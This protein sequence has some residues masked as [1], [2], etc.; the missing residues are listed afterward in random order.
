MIF[1]RIC[2]AIVIIF[3]RRGIGYFWYL[4]YGWLFPKIGVAVLDR[5]PPHAIRRALYVL[6]VI[7]ILI[8]S[9][10]IFLL[11]PS[12]TATTVLLGECVL[13]ILMRVVLP[14]MKIAKMYKKAVKYFAQAKK[15]YSKTTFTIWEYFPVDN[16][17]RKNID[18]ALA[19][20]NGNELVIAKIDHDL[21]MCGFYGP[22]PGLPP[23]SSEEFLQRPRTEIAVV[24]RDGFVLVKKDLKGS[25][26]G[27]LREWYNSVFLY[28]KINTP[29]VYDV[30]E[31]RCII[32]KN[33]VLGDNLRDL[34]VNAGARIMHTQN[35]NDPEIL[36]LEPAVR[37]LKII[38]R[39]ASVMGKTVTDEFL[40]KLEDQVNIMHRNGMV[41][42]VPTF[43]NIIVDKASGSPFLID[44]ESSYQLSLKNP[45]FWYKRNNGR[46]KFNQ[47][48]HAN[49]LTDESARDEVRSFTR[50]HPNWYAPIDLGQGFTIG[51]FW[52]TDSGTGRWD[53]LNGK[54]IAPLVRGKRVLDLGSNNGL[55][56]LLMLR[57]GAKEVVGI[58][59]SPVFSEAARLVKRL[60]EWR[61]MQRFNFKLHEGDMRMIL[62][63][64]WGEFDVVT[65]FCSLYYLNEEDMAAVVQH[66]SN[67]SPTMI[68]QANIGTRRNAEDNKADK[69]STKYLE[70]LLIDSG[71]PDVKI[72]APKGFTRPLLI[73]QK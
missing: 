22:I 38:E 12:L 24:I 73:G 41:N 50:S 64:D 60:F 14:K 20:K 47:R 69:S 44:F 16:Q 58:E 71:Y 63:V 6:I 25:R 9:V 13:A 3:R 40:M 45:I 42:I 7:S 52:S 30:D 51:G 37:S 61:Y 67:L 53:Y 43:G 10:L 65:A 33:F 34:L 32:Y 59:M 70:K 17:T 4:F 49:I 31:D 62:S 68:L 26:L 19:E 56:P 27:F 66:V 21:R 5:Y 29:A 15:T 28:G 55:N 1:Y 57:D 54:I 23:V 18:L 11:L 39:G 48:F 72:F 36:S 46:K 8:N 2:H 35:H